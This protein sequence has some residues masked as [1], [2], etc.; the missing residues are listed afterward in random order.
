MQISPDLPFALIAN[1]WEKPIDFNTLSIL[2]SFVFVSDRKITYG[3]C[4]FIR[5]LR[6]LTVK[7]LQM[8]RQFQP[9]AI[10]GNIILTE[11]FLPLQKPATTTNN[12]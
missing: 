12:S 5:T 10:I 1:F 2:S 4:T 7:A 11:H 9:K 3:L 8:A 6:A